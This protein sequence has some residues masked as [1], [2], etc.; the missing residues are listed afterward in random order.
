ML[1]VPQFHVQQEHSLQ[2]D[3]QHAKTVLKAHIAQA[4]E[5]P[6]K[7]NAQSVIYRWRKRRK[8]LIKINFN[9]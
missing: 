7:L 4:L 8:L 3:T 2:K 1:M 6:V 5:H 9:R